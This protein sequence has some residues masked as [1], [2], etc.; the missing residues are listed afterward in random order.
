MAG[1]ILFEIID[2]KIALITLNRIASLNSLNGSLVQEFNKVLDE[3]ANNKKI[4]CVILTGAGK[5]FCAGGDLSYLESLQE[6]TQISSFIADV[7][8]LAEKIYHLPKPV[9]AMVN[10]VAAGAGFNL[11]LACDLI[12]ATD[13][14]RFSQSFAKVGLIPD[15]G[16]LYFLQKQIGPYKAKQ[17][18]FTAE[19]IDC[20]QG[21]KLGFINKICEAEFLYRE[22]L[23]LAEKLSNGAPLALGLIKKYL[24]E[25]NKT[26]E[27]TLEVEKEQ[28]TICLKTA[29]FSEGVLA[30]KEKREPIFIG[31]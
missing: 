18:M 20:E 24:N 9:I 14:A 1:E 2:D 17:L 27:Q 21:Y 4:R 15:C 5:G 11:V 28:Q 29:D 30:F 3:C 25:D 12:Y 19:L 6:E 16:G 31:K 26:L 8:L 10:G 22:T 7:G 23:E 13:T